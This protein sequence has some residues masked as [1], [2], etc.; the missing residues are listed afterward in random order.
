MRYHSQNLN[1]SHG[2]I[3]GSM[4]W[5]GR[6]WLHARHEVHWEW[7]LGKYARQFAATIGFGEGDSDA[8]VNLH[9]CIPFLFSIYIGIAGIWRLKQPHSVGVAIHNC[10]F[11]IYTFTND[12]EW[13]RDMPWWEKSHCWHFPW[14]YDWHSTEILEHKANHP[15]YGRL[16][17]TVRG[18]GITEKW[19]ADGSEKQ[20]KE[21]ASESYSYT[22][23]LKKG[24]IQHV[25]ATVYVDRMTWRMRWWPLLPFQKSRTC[26]N[27]T[28]NSEIGERTGSWKGGVLGCGYEMLV[29]ET[30]LECLRRMETERKFN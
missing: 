8:G 7:Y 9:L 24:E 3:I 11:W 23:R 6:A 4:F 26:I 1:E 30:P 10:A 5:R 16:W 12:H 29:G 28:F 14:D 18:R 21:F 22:Y 20:T 13:R 27:V 25:K 17:M 2:Q 19:C 15:G